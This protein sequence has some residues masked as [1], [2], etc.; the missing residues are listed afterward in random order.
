ME[1]YNGSN[2]KAEAALIQEHLQFTLANPT[3]SAAS[4]PGRR[5]DGKPSA[6]TSNMPWI[7]AR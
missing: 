5:C 1:S 6:V 2:L 7:T 4:G 3:A